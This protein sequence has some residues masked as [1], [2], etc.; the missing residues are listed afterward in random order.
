MLHTNKITALNNCFSDLDRAATSFYLDP[1][2]EN[3]AIFLSHALKIIQ[4]INDTNLGIFK[5]KI[6]TFKRLTSKNKLSKKER[7]NIADEILTTGVL[8][9]P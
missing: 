1:K 6:L 5:N 3:H 8:L 7:L 9:K 2:G 4:E